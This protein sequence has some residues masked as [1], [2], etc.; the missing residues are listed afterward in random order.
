MVAQSKLLFSLCIPNV[1]PTICISD[2]GLINERMCTNAGVAA[3]RQHCWYRHLHSCKLVDY[4]C[5]SYVLAGHRMVPSIV[6]RVF[7]NN[8]LY[9]RLRLSSALVCLSAAA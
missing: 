8:V 6:S 2:W 3:H 1:H 5:V 4:T 7:S 9:L